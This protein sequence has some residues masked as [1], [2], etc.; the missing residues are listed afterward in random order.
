SSLTD[1]SS[2][3]ALA[4]LSHLRKRQARHAMPLTGSNASAPCPIS[5]AIFPGT[6]KEVCRLHAR[7]IITIVAHAKSVRDR[8]ICQLPSDTR[9]ISLQ[10][11]PSHMAIACRNTG[12]KPQPAARPLLHCRP[13]LS[14]SIHQSHSNASSVSCFTFLTSCTSSS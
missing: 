12:T 3:V 6:E 7:R 4:N 1:P 8:P 14:C 10:P 2:L 9:C 11:T 13:E 5:R